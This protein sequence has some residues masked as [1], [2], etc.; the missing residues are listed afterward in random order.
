MYI[1]LFTDPPSF[2]K[3]TRINLVF[4]LGMAAS[5]VGIPIYFRFR[6]AEKQREV[7]QLLEMY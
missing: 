7:Q 3:A 2:H 1:W 6:N 4:S 5:S